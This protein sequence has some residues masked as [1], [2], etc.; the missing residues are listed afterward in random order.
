MIGPD[1]RSY[2][3]EGISSLVPVP[4][5]PKGLNFCTDVDSDILSCLDNFS[6]PAEW[7]VL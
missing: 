2:G 1:E 4:A 7:D 3:S 6:H 5:R